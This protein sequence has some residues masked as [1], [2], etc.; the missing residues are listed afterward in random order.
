MK[1]YKFLTSFFFLL[2]LGC[3]SDESEEPISE[4]NINSI[5]PLQ[6]KIGDT[7][8]ISGTNLTRLDSIYFLYEDRI[9]SKDTI[10]VSLI[11][12]DENEIT[13]KMPEVLTVLPSS[14]MFGR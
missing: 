13:L 9:Y 12:R 4:Y 8:K 10:N 6:V 5:S 3:G 7:I 14:A 1:N 2:I 11:T